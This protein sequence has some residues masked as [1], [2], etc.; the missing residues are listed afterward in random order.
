MTAL[1]IPLFAA[2]LNRVLR[3]GCLR[4]QILNGLLTFGS[5]LAYVVSL[6]HIPFAELTVL[7]FS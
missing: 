5:Q 6:L 4:L 1:L 3:T 2:D 7:G